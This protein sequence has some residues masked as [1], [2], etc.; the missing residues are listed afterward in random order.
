MPDKKQVKF[1]P[2]SKVSSKSHRSAHESSRDSGVG[3]SSSGSGGGL[4]DRWSTAR[5][6]V[7][8]RSEASDADHYKAKY[9]EVSTQLSASVKAQKDSEQYHLQRTM[10]F[11]SKVSRLQKDKQRLEDDYHLLRQQY[12]DLDKEYKCL[13]EDFDE[14]RQT[15]Q[16]TIAQSAHGEP[17]MSGGLGEPSSRIGRSKSKRGKENRDQTEHTKERSNRESKSSH[18]ATSSTSSKR[19]SHRPSTVLT[20]T[21]KPYIEEMP[22]ASPTAP[23]QFS[24]NYA[25]ASYDTATYSSLPRTMYSAGSLPYRGADYTPGDYVEYPLSSSSGLHG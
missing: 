4:S 8:P 17:M 25:T 3:S 13:E 22:P 18:K 24:D 2:Q 10:E 21:K 11:E 16:H 19:H 15:Y 14:L 6:Y 23:R 12:K 7:D 9:R 5:D 20:G 1:A